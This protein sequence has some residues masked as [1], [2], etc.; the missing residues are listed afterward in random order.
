MRVPE[1]SFDPGLR[2]EDTYAHR[3]SDRA[4]SFLDAHGSEDFVVVSYDEP[5][6][7]SICPEPYA[8]MYE[9]FTRRVGPAA[10][11]APSGKPEHQKVWA[12][13]ALS[14]NEG[15]AS[16][17]PVHSGLQLFLGAQSF[18]DE[19]IGRVLDAA[20]RRSPRALVL[21]TSDH[22][23]ALR[24]HHLWGKGPAAY[25]EIARVPL[26][27]S[28]PGQ[29]GEGSVRGGV[30]SRIDL[31]PTVMEALGA[32][33][34]RTMSGRSLLGDDRR[35]DGAR[36]GHA[37]IEFGRYEV[38]H[39]GFGGFQ[40]MRA[41]TDGRHKLVANLLGEDE[42]YDMEGDPAELVNVIDS[43]EHGAARERLHETLLEW[44]HETRDPFRGD[45]SERR[46][47]RAEA[48]AP[49]WAGRGAA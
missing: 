8:S 42:L 37:A 48:P 27:L 28:W 30:A 31:G 25:D 36:S 47:W 45:Q 22:G 17:I 4:V 38:D 16:E 34:P 46:P 26:I 43:P 7:P 18:V 29:L 19:E 41:V 35:G 1:T 6:G 20:A 33:V 13:P 40:P 12:A 21:Y 5:H 44:M 11:D 10:S 9:G 39:D 49:S 32:P 23:E 2:H 15:P 24:A 14:A 3:C